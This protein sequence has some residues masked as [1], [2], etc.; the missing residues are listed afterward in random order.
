MVGDNRGAVTVYRVLD[1]ITI[2]HEGPVQQMGRLKQVNPRHRRAL[3]V[4]GSTPPSSGHTQLLSFYPSVLTSERARILF[5]LSGH[6]AAVR[7]DQ[8][9]PAEAGRG[10]GGRNPGGWGRFRPGWGG[11][12]PCRGRRKRY[13]PIICVTINW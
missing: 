8:R 9:R 7:P 6:Y 2:T 12:R 3:A 11:E 13:L 10:G 5:F 4:Y 1:P